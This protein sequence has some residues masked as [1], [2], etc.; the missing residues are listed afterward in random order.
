MTHGLNFFRTTSESLAFV[1]F[2]TLVAREQNIFTMLK[3]VEYEYKRRCSKNIKEKCS[4]KKK[5][6]YLLPNILMYFCFP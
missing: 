6:L 1:F 3:R 4:K 5:R 2:Q